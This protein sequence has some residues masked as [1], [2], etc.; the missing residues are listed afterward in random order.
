VMVYAGVPMVFRKVFVT[1]IFGYPKGLRIFWIFLP[2]II[3][4]SI[5]ILNFFPP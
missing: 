2:A 5:S 4:E 3:E 1:R